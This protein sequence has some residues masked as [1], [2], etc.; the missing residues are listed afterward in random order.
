[1]L[2][3]ALLAVAGIAE[4]SGVLVVAA[5]IAGLVELAPIPLDD[6]LTVPLIS[7]SFAQYFPLLMALGSPP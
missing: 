3:L 7:G 5:L 2:V 1:M 6:N 4:F